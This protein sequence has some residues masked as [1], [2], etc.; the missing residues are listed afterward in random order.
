MARFKSVAVYLSWF[1]L[2]SHT[3]ASRLVSARELTRVS[4]GIR[5]VNQP[6]VAWNFDT[7]LLNRPNDLHGIITYKTESGSRYFRRLLRGR[8]IEREL[9]DRH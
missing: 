9:T 4:P 2:Y 1:A 3:S 8:I 7:I 6:R 5:L